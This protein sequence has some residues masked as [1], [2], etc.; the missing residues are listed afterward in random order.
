VINLWSLPQSLEFLEMS[1]TISEFHHERW[2]GLG[3]PNGLSSLDI[4]LGARIMAIADVFDALTSKRVYKKAISI[5]DATIYINSQSGKHFD[6]ELIISFNR[7]QSSLLNIF[8]TF[9]E[10]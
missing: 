3:Y 9:G 5:K 4:P 1:K 7:A 2:D 6:P 8:N 10:H